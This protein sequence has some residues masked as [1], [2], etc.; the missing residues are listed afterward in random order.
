[1][2]P[3]SSSTVQ[4]TVSGL[5]FRGY[6][7]YRLLQSQPP[8]SLSIRTF[9]RHAFLLNKIPTTRQLDTAN[10]PQVQKFPSQPSWSVQALLPPSNHVP[11]DL[12]L[13]SE[14]LRHLLRLAALPE[15]KT[16]ADEAE[17]LRDL[18]SQLHFVK[19]LQQVDT[20]G[21]EPLR[22]IRD[23]SDEAEK[24]AEL[25]VDKLKHAFDGEHVVGH[26]YRRIR[27]RK[28]PAAS[29]VDIDT[30]SHWQPLEHAQTPQ[31]KYFVVDKS[32]SH[33]RQES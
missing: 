5:I 33:R 8:Q 13:T 21:V 25:T 20:E 19:Q 7:P 10:E 17:M 24:A 22:A 4:M 26:H 6:T 2:L 1:M 12:G 15:P 23:E 31:G 28:Q 29:Q 9:S 16:E 32:Q 27:R 18:A 30:P 11:A 3:L 14:K